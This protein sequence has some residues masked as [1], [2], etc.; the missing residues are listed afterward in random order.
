MRARASCLLDSTPYEP[1]HPRSS[2][3]ILSA[4]CGALTVTET[5]P[6]SLR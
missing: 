5:L 3:T 2:T 6:V 4:P 1:Q